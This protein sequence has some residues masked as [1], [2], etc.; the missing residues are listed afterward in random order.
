M[1]GI[2]DHLLQKSISGKLLY[3]AELIPQ[4]GRQ[5]EQFVDN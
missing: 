4:A 1:T 2:H 5:D 3:T